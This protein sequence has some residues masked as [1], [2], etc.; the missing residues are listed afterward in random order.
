MFRNLMLTIVTCVAFSGI[1]AA[2][3]VLTPERAIPNQYIVVLD[4]VQTSRTQVAPR[5]QALARQHGGRVLH[6]YEHA[7]RGFAASMSATAAAAIARSPGVR[8]VEQDSVMSI[9]ATQPNATWGL[10]RIDQRNLPLNA[11]YTYDTSAVN[12][13]VY[14]I[15]T[16]SGTGSG[17]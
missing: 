9:V 15:D 13:E 8:Y 2:Q 12:V 10:D 7:V 4:D 17:G 6:L 1:A 14:V 3:Q 11:T 16:G 5:A